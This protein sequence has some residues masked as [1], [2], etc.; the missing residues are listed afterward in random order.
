MRHWS[1]HFPNLNTSKSACGKC[2]REF[3]NTNNRDRHAA[4]CEGNPDNANRTITEAT[5]N[6]LE[7]D[8]VADPAGCTALDLGFEDWPKINAHR[9]HIDDLSCDVGPS[10]LGECMSSGTWLSEPSLEQATTV[11]AFSLQPTNLTVNPELDYTSF[12]RMLASPLPQHPFP[13]LGIDQGVMS[14]PAYTNALSGSRKRA[15]EDTPTHVSKRHK[16][17]MD[18]VSNLSESFTDCDTYTETGGPGEVLLAEP[19]GRTTLRKS[20]IA[21]DSI[22]LG[23]QARTP[24]IVAVANDMGALKNSATSMTNLPLRPLKQ[25]DLLEWSYHTAQSSKSKHIEIRKQTAAVKTFVRSSSSLQASSYD[26]Y[27][28]IRKLTR[29]ARKITD[30]TSFLVNDVFVSKRTRHPRVRNAETVTRLQ[31]TPLSFGCTY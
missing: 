9:D 1:S 14:R 15:I 11:H 31:L 27:T 21:S 24:R 29:K 5:A 19:P 30:T 23:S 3:A 18:R 7:P 6:H 13:T 28:W 26:H 17:S 12:E 16:S 25:Y 2:G 10:R 22:N 20:D 4:K 8:L